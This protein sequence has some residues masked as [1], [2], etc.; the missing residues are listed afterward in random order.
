LCCRCR[1][2]QSPNPVRNTEVKVRAAFCRP[3]R[4]KVGERPA[5]LRRSADHQPVSIRRF[6]IRLPSGAFSRDYEQAARGVE[7]TDTPRCAS[8]LIASSS[9]CGTD[10]PLCPRRPSSMLCL[11]AA[12]TWLSSDVRSPRR[13]ANQPV[14]LLHVWSCAWTTPVSSTLNHLAEPS[15][16]VPVF[17][18]PESCW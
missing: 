9:Q 5:V 6:A 16:I 3:P 4:R 11:Q 1:T 10:F 12:D 15:S 13:S 17:D 7:K 8:Q 18:D 2:R 14:N